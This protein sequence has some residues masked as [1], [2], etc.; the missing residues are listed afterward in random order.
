MKFVISINFIYKYYKKYLLHLTQ[1][2]GGKK[3]KNSY[4]FESGSHFINSSTLK[5]YRLALFCAAFLFSSF[6]RGIL[7]PLEFCILL[8]Q[9]I[10]KLIT[11][12]YLLKKKGM[13]KLTNGIEF[14]K[15]WEYSLKVEIVWRLKYSVNPILPP[16][17]L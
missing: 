3:Y 13:M 4:N 12:Y 8:A 16:Y 5:N 15:F 17:F 9:I 1:K 6:R 2:K 11:K 14:I 7:H 10:K